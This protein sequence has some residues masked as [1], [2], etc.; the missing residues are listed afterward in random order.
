MFDELEEDKKGFGKGGI[1]H[2]KMRRMSF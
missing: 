1:N 2:Y